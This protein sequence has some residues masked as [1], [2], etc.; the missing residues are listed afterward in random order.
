MIQKTAKIVIYRKNET[1]QQLIKLI[2]KELKS[3]NKS[4]LTPNKI[5]IG[6]SV[7]DRIEKPK[8]FNDLKIQPF[9]PN[10]SKKAGGKK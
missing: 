8:F 1:I 2:S 7:F 3:M 4:G 6:Y 10:K 9:L 5:V